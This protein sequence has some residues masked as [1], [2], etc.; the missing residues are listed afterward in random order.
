[1]AMF[2]EI[3]DHSL[4]RDVLDTNHPLSVLDV[5]SGKGYLTFALYEYLS[6]KWQKDVS[7][8]TNLPETAECKL[9]TILSS[10]QVLSHRYILF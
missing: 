10:V 8:Y 3:V 5:G 4:K 7:K 6:K 9:A 2:I 1:M